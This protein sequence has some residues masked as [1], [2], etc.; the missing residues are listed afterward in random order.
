MK[1]PPGGEAR[2]NLRQIVVPSPRGPV[3]RMLLG[4]SF[5]LLNLDSVEYSVWLDSDH[6][7]KGDCI[8]TAQEDGTCHTSLAT[9][10]DPGT[11]SKV[12]VEK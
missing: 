6:H 10:V 3:S 1:P 8:G 9:K 2:R 7:E 5:S 11:H 12:G 4:L